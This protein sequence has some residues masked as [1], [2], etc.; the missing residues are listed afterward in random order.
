MHDLHFDCALLDRRNRGRKLAGLFRQRAV[1]G[2]AGQD[3]LAVIDLGVDAGDSHSNG[4]AFAQ[5]ALYRGQWQSFW[6]RTRV[7]GINRGVDR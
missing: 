3:D 1:D 7:M 2:R 4:K 5:F 6:R